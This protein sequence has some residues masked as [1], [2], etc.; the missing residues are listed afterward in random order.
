MGKNKVIERI[1]AQVE[2]NKNADTLEEKDQA[3]QD[4]TKLL[5]DLKLVFEFVVI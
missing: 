3:L 5:G 1:Q 2:K 4:S